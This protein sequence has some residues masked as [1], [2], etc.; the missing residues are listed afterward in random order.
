MHVTI[1]GAGTLGRVYGL[2]LLAA[3]DEVAFVVRPSRMAEES[4]F[5]LEQVNGDHR[6]DVREQPRRVTAVA[7]TTRVVLLAVRFDQMASEEVASLLRA[8]PSV[9]I[10]VLTPLL[11]RQQA[12]LEAA[13]G[14]R[15]TAAMP[16]VS[17]YFDERGVVRHWIIK[18]ASTLIDETGLGE[19][20]RPPLE[21][22]ARHLTREGI[23]TH[24]EAHVGSLNVA[25]TSA[26]FPLIASIN[27]GGGVDG[28]LADKELL[29]TTLDAAQ[30]TAA[31]GAKLGKVAPWA[32]VLTKF[33]GPFTI[34]PG[35]ALARRLAPEAVRFAE[36]HFGPK[37]HEQHLAM[38]AAILELGRDHDQAMPALERLMDRVR[39]RGGEA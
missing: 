29:A 31:L 3:G 22:L 21:E 36:Q 10:V 13:S 11:P 34:K 20:S 14:R 18:L 9:P 33:V 6:R 15:V 17:G 5:V 28:V 2:R 35:V 37:L 32:N 27:A 16:S 30:E 38:G 12:A 7:A 4:A 39:A 26:F 23:A 25:T 19:A 8:A 24:L 1:I